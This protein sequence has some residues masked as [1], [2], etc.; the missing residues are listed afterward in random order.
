[1][2]MGSRLQ[3][4]A[5]SGNIGSNSVNIRMAEGTKTPYPFISKEWPITP[6]HKTPYKSHINDIDNKKYGSGFIKTTTRRL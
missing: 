1:M 5:D 3:M 6:P 4:F 2:D